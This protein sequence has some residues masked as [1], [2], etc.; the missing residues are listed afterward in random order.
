LHHRVTAL[1]GVLLM[2]DF[3]TRCAQARVTAMELIL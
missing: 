2:L 1:A 3:S